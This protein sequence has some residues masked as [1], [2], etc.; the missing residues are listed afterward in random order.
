MKAHVYRSAKRD[1][2]YVYLR[3][4]GDVSVLPGPLVERLGELIHVMDVELTPE[5]KLARVDAA[6]VR[7]NLARVGY[8]L[9]LPPV[10]DDLARARR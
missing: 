10:P 9:Q 4:A 3:D 5:R 2:T 1:D 8:F 7:D 6:V